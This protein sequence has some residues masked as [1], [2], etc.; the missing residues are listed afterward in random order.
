MRIYTYTCIHTYI[1][2]IIYEYKKSA[3]RSSPSVWGL[4][5]Q[6]V[7]VHVRGGERVRESARGSVWYIRHIYLYIY[8]RIFIYNDIRIDQSHPVSAFKQG[9]LRAYVCVCVYVKRERVCVCVFSCVFACVYTYMYTFQ[10]TYIWLY[11]SRQV[12]GGE[13]S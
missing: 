9:I 3:C 10:Y 4:P 8:K 1:Y 6:R 12:Q 7:C 2:I 11:I 13:D 5:R